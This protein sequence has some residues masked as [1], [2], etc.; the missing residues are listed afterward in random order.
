MQDKSAVSK[1]HAE[2]TRRL[3]QAH[4]DEWRSTLRSVYEEM[5]L[6]VRFR[7]TKEEKLAIELE[8]A[9]LLLAQHGEA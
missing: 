9:R 4:S 6:E 8:K 7:S 5:G 1:A 2:A 3:K